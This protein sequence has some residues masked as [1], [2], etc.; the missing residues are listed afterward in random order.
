MKRSL[1]LI[2]CIILSSIV[3][4]QGPNN[5]YDNIAKK[6]NVK[7]GNKIVTGEELGNNGFNFI[8]Y[9]PGN[10]VNTKFSEFGSGLFRDK[11]IVVSSRKIG[12][13][14]KIDKNTNEAYKM[15]FCS[16]FNEDTSVIKQPLLFSRI[17]NTKNANESM[18]SFSPDEHTI[19]FTRSIK[20]DS[21]IY[22]LRKATLEKKSHGNW[23]NEVVLDINKAGYS[24]ESPFVSPD[25]QKLFFASNMPGTL[26]GYDLFVAPI[27]KDG[28]LGTP[29]N[30]GENINTS[31]NEN[32]PSL[33]KDGR[34]LFFASQGHINLGGYDTFK[35][36]IRNEKFETPVNLGNTVNTKADEVALF[37]TSENNGYVSSNKIAGEGGFNIAKFE[38]NVVRQ[39][40]EG[41][42]LDE[43][44]QIPLPN[45]TITLY[46]I[47]GKEV[48]KT[49][50]EADG[51]Y[52]FTVLPNENY[53]I[54][55]QKNGFIEN[56]FNFIADKGDNRT[57]TKDLILNATE[58]I[59]EKKE[60]KLFISVEN[61][62]FDYNKADIK[63]E[64]YIALNKVVAVLK[65]N[66][67]MKIEVNAHTD[68]QGTNDYNS[69]LS[70]KRAEAAKQYLIQKGVDSNRLI[71][72]GFG[73]TQPLVNCGDNCSE[74]EH[75][76]NRRIEFIILNK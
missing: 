68:T 73:E 5:N 52:S 54:K 72:K 2:T 43:I 18:V 67:N 61:I 30:L 70:S 7:T 19:Y 53:R 50:T 64:S 57:Y 69:K 8:K 39:N 51:S 26:G 24:I 40:L 32:Y 29:K 63:K 44:T 37:F 36:N 21:K 55:T 56:T 58:A 76:S 49:T 33:S 27:K 17:L 10:I 11:L 25:G 4:G 42:V 9:K 20:E 74:Q 6:L 59:I 13:L 1:L 71:A 28:T 38:Y 62:Y 60:N 12:G 46:D 35:S 16:D 65:N 41:T 14:A 34:T 45:T 75:L 23:E 31:L 66:E 15:L 47:E 48:E 3:Y 22:E